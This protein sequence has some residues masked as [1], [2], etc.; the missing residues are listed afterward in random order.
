MSR[1]TSDGGDPDRLR[2]LATRIVEQI[3]GLPAVRTLFATMEA[4]DRG[5]GGLTAAGLAYTSL[6]AILPGLL[7]IASA[8]GLWV[9]DPEV[10]AQIVDWIGRAVPPL[11]DVAEAALESVSQG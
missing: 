10:R 8:I 9:D 6:L 1:A 2:A 5:G 7:L 4:Y 3:G 11:E